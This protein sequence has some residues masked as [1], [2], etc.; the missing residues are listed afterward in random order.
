MY[1]G[2]ALY[3]YKQLVRFAVA[4]GIPFRSVPFAS[5]KTH[6]DGWVAGLMVVIGCCNNYSTTRHKHTFPARAFVSNTH[7]VCCCARFR[8]WY[9]AGWLAGSSQN[10]SNESHCPK[11]TYIVRGQT[12]S[13]S[14]SLV[15]RS[16]RGAHRINLMTHLFE[17]QCLF[18]GV[19]VWFGVDRGKH[20]LCTILAFNMI[21]IIFAPKPTTY[22]H[23]QKKSSKPC[24]PIVAIYAPSRFMLARSLCRPS[25]AP[26][27]THTLYNI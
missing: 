14:S 11:C 7:V 4:F 26:E 12:S 16:V 21:C 22:S 25:I 2:Y 27:V 24:G 20:T 17:I 23:T 3:K 15:A 19:C 1:M 18:G 10:T 13:S 9:C 6:T 8:C 5:S